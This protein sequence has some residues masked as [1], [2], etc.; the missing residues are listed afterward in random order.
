[1]SKSLAVMSIILSFTS[2]LSTFASEVRC[3]I[4]KLADSKW[5]DLQLKKTAEFDRKYQNYAVVSYSPEYVRSDEKN[6]LGIVRYSINLNFRDAHSTMD[7][8]IIA[9]S[10]E[11][12]NERPRAFGS[13]VKLREISTGDRF[14][15]N[16]GTERVFLICEV[17]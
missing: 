12:P 6:T 11:K 14:S 4:S 8:V 2:S 16:I 10:I 9:A 5:E 13:D 15:L 3:G 1:M 17:N 7:E